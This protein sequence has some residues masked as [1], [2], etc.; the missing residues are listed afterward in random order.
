MSL[1]K[2]RVGALPKKTLFLYM[3]PISKH[4]GY[5]TKRLKS[6]DMY[7]DHWF[8]KIQLVYDVEN[9]MWKLVQSI[10]WKRNMYFTL[11]HYL[12]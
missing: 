3:S 8:E 10:A 2:K 6:F 1:C 9:T 7:K 5:V 11:M 12:L 4:I